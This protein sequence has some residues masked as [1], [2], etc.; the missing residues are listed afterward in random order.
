MRR[1]S[2]RL[3]QALWRSPLPVGTQWHTRSD[4]EMKCGSIS[5]EELMQAESRCLVGKF[6]F[7]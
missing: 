6:R 4:V 5:A 1:T 2:S 3:W 7:R